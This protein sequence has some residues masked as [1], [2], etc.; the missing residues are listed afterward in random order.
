MSE[1]LDEILSR[2][3]NLMPKSARVPY[4]PISFERGKGAKLYDVDGKEY[5]DFLASA[6]S[7]N[8]GHGN[9]EIAQ[10]AYEQMTTLAQYIAAYFPSQPS[11]D[12]AER[13]VGMTGRENI[14][15]SFTSTGSASI[16]GAIK[17]ARGYTGRAKIIS[18]SESYHGSTYGAISVS[19]LTNNMRRKIGPLLPECE[20][21]NYPTCLRCHYH[22]KPET[23]QLD[24]VKQI[25]YAF[26]HY[27]PPDEVA[28]FLIEPIAGDAGM[29]VP[30]VKYYQKLRELCDAHG[31]LLIADEINQ[32]LGR[33]G[34]LF[35]M[36]NFGIV[37]DLYVLGKS[38][39]GGLPLGA[40]IGRKDV[41]EVLEGPAHSFT[42]SGHATCCT[43]SLKM[44]EI[45][46]R[47]GLFAQSM[48]K[49]AYLK[50]KLLALQE[51]YLVI[52][53]VR[54]IGLNFGMDLVTDRETM[55]KNPEATAKI[56]YACMKNGLVLTFLAQSVLRIQP[57]LVITYEELDR[58]VAIMDEALD[59][60]TKGEL[61]DEILEE[62]QGW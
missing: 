8:I 12:L 9:E 10:V 27:M 45:M 30:P 23:C 3:D 47:E 38:L 22:Q 36:D 34:T 13:L 35:S 55:N 32:G 49:G 20:K 53:E 44:L 48:E 26:D 24:C 62:M 11:V 54:G 6:S 7:A 43:T 42:M 61:G 15:V 2:Q 52:G 5:I 39:G 21:M 41:M 19:A 37:C 4:I 17:Y 16:D 50:E 18:F 60:Y 57:P 58:A 31:I 25:A 40:V 28:A 59:A 51:K 1:K 56:S 14:M 46:E 29:L 33:A